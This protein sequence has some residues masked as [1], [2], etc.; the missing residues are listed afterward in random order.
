LIRCLNGCI[1]RSDRLPFALTENIRIGLM[2][3][4]LLYGILFFLLLAILRR[5]TSCLLGSLLLVLLLCIHRTGLSYHFRS[6]HKLVLYDIPGKEHIDIFQGQRVW[7]WGEDAPG[8]DDPQKQ[9]IL[10]A[11]RRAHGIPEDSGKPPV[12]IT[13]AL[14]RGPHQ[15]VLHIDRLF[16][17]K[18]VKKKIPVDLI[19]LGPSQPYPITRIAAVFTAKQYIFAA[20]TPLW[21][22]RYWKKEADSLHLRH[23]TISE[24]GA[25]EMEL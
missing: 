16:Q 13:Q 11:S 8:S 19:I 4:L 22:I 23:H 18:P 9:N 17:L 14:Y 21:K 20:G 12:Q 5:N 7:I 3:T 24:Q 15:T 2:E 1:E 25:F 10:A 6:Q